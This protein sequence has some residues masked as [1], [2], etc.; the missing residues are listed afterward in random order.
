MNVID[1]PQGIAFM[2]LLARKAALSLEIKGLKRHGRS[3][4]SICKEVYGLKG[5]RQSVLNQMQ[6]MVDK[7]LKP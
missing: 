6:A 7:V 1:T 4:Y 5:T 3:A 2:Q